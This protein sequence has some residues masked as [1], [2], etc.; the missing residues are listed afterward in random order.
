[1]AFIH[2]YPNSDGL[3]PKSAGLNLIVMLKLILWPF[4]GVGATMGSDSWWNGQDFSSTGFLR[5]ATQKHAVP[6]GVEEVG[7]C[8][9]SFQ[10]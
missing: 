9:T 4:R 3:Q 1:M 7:T 2:L 8:N 5:Q 10:H 6:A